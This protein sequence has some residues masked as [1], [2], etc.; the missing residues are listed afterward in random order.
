MRILRTNILSLLLLLVPSLLMAQLQRPQSFKERYTLKEVVIL[1]RHSIRSPL[2]T[3]GSALSRLTPHQWINW[4][5]ASSELTLRGGV[6]ETMMGQYFRKWLVDE[7]LFEENAVPTTD[8]VNFYANSM[9]RTIAT[10]QYFSSGFMPLANVRVNHRYNASKMDP[11]F[12]PRL[13]KVSDAFCQE[14]LKQIAA[15]GGKKGIVGINEKLKDSYAVTAKVLDLKD[16]PA[17]KSG[18]TCAFDDY[19]TQFIF[20]LYDEPKM[21]GSLKLANS[22]SDAFIL[23]Y[24]EEP[25]AKKAA[26]GHDITLSDWEKIAK[27]KDVYGDVLF[28]APIVAAN[29]AHPLLVYLNDEL[30]SA[31]RKFT[32]LCGHDSNIASVDAALGVDDYEL[33]NSIE[34]KTPIGSKVV[35]EK[36]SDK[37]GKEFVAV[38]IVYQTTDQLRGLKMLSLDNPPMV[39]SLKLKGLT[40][41]A[42]GLYTFED[43]NGRFV[44]AIRAY[45]AIK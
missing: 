1:S 42:D 13:T 4:T 9:Q 39:Y 31:G 5:S 24:Y 2:S 21:K 26:F 27:I 6:L 17:C 34:K 11:V 20:K 10:A 44:E 40:A 22:A 12:C 23:Q 29:V 43:V 19:N 37:S 36:W 41:N 7:G 33:P 3:N 45:D 14:A 38:N 15:M 32:F 30:N 25:D 35:F 18:E 16:S 28:T 8:E